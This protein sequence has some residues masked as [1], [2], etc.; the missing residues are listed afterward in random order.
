[1]NQSVVGKQTELRNGW[2][3]REDI[4]INQFMNYNEVND[5]YISKEIQR[6]LEERNLYLSKGLNL[7]C[8]KSKCFNCQDTTEC[9]ICIKRHKCELCKIPK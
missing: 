2:F 1:M 3:K 5:Q 6:V 9:K 4:Q 8:S 7:K